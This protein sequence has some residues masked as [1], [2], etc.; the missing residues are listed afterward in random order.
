M[1]HIMDWGNVQ[2]HPW[3]NPRILSYTIANIYNQKSE[4]VVQILPIA[5][6]Y[7]ISEGYLEKVKIKRWIFCSFSL[8]QVDRLGE[9]LKVSKLIKIL[10][11]SKNKDGA[12]YKYVHFHITC[13][14]KNGSE[15][16][17]N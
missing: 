10:L 14:Y 7:G 1:Y 11:S 15:H 12:T 5:C 17:R 8:T 3:R 2:T 4:S 13:K 6:Q 9:K 16:A